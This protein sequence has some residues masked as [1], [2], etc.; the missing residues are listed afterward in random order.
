MSDLFFVL[1][2]TPNLNCLVALLSPHF[3][4]H[5]HAQ[6]PA[7]AT[8]LSDLV[9][10]ACVPVR[11]LWCVRSTSFPYGGEVIVCDLPIAPNGAGRQAPT[12]GGEGRSQGWHLAF[13]SSAPRSLRLGRVPGKYMGIVLEMLLFFCFLVRDNLGQFASPIDSDIF[14]QTGLMVRMVS[15]IANTEKRA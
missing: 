11:R 7:S 4:L 1:V 6:R 14:P 2:C 9:Y 12:F 8:G 3:S 15:D 5:M 13:F 10:F